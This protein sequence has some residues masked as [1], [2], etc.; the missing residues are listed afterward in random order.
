[1]AYIP[2]PNGLGLAVM[3]DPS[4]LGLEGDVI[5]NKLGFGLARMWVLLLLLIIF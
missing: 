2:D 3:P 4:G 5:P 1:L